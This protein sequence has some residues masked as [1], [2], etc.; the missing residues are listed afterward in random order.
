MKK[1]QDIA[2]FLFI[3]ALGI[4]TV[5]SVLGI[6]DFFARDVISKS[7]QTV[8]LLA[9]VAVVV[10]I[11]GKYFD[12]NKN[13]TGGEMSE[14]PNPVFKIVRHVTLALLIV[15]A[16]ILALVGVFAIWDVI[17]DSSVLYKSISSLA[18]IAFSSFLIVMTCLVRENSPLLRGNNGGVSG[19]KIVLFAVLFIV[20]FYFLSFFLFSF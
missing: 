13:T 7:F 5:I 16:S 17:T 9:L 1:I 20:L 14:L 8:G 3:S 6:W 15:V 10:I 11:S 4:L 12:K 19:V 18:I 2:G